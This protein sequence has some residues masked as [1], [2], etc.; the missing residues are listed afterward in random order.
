LRGEWSGVNAK[1][2]ETVRSRALARFHLLGATMPATEILLGELKDLRVRGDERG[3]LVALEE[4]DVGFAIKRAYYIYGTQPGVARGGHA[5]RD[6]EQL[7]VCLSGS[8][9]FVLDDGDVREEVRLDRPDLG[10]RVSSMIWREMR[11]FSPDSVLLVLASRPYDE[12]DYIRS[13]EDFLALAR[14]T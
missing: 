11:D 10:L 9:L 1:L 7:V 3:S 8:C 13:Y 5:H 12:A 4:P 2:F 6:L 14:R